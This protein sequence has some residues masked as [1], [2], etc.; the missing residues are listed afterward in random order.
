MDII[1][2]PGYWLNASSWDAVV[3]DLEQAGHRVRALTLPGLESVDTDR[4]AVT[5]RDQIDHV[6]AEVDSATGPVVLV[7]HSAGGGVASA[8]ADARPDRV[9]RVIYVG[10]EPRGSDEGGSPFKAEGS[11]VP[12][13]DWD[14]FDDE[15]VA[16]L[17][18]AL[19]ATIEARAVPVPTRAAN[20]PLVLTDERRYDIPITMVCCEFPKSQYDEWLADGEEGV[21]E[22][23]KVHDVTWVEIGGG[24]WPQFSQPEALA[25]TILDAIG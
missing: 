12:L 11:D 21:A 22:L 19:R 17:D 13:P 5:L 15:M 24:H 20:D 6:I 14:F 9:A 23:A 1:L 3:P 8:A 25:G 10:S 4:S 18:G 16:D 7:G 2:I